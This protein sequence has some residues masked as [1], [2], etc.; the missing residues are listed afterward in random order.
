VVSVHL[1]KEYS[2]VYT[3][4]YLC[5][6]KLAIIK[7]TNYQFQIPNQKSY[8]DYSLGRIS[9]FASFNLELYRKTE[10]MNTSF[11]LGEDQDLYFKLEEV[12]EI[13]YIDEALYKYRLN[14]ESISNVKRYRFRNNY[15][16]HVDRGCNRYH[17]WNSFR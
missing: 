5:D 16:N 11:K 10:G 4:R 14:P 12:G 3:D 9:H 7:A 8:L 17:N 2:L 1:E 6:E 15:A 13:K